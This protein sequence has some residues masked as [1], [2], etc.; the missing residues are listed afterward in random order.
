MVLRVLRVELA[1][2]LQRERESAFRRLAVYALKHA[3]HGYFEAY[4]ATAKSS[5]F[6]RDVP[7]ERSLFVSLADSVHEMPQIAHLAVRGALA[8][9]NPAVVSA[10][11]TVLRLY[12][13][14]DADDPIRQVVPPNPGR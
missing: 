7:S 4:R 13:E 5:R 6:A 2:Y 9:D 1:P 14:L 11:E 8:D 12:P 3:G 10:G